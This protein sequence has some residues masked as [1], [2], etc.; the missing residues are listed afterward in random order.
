MRENNKK[1]GIFI[2]IIIV[3]LV[4]LFRQLG[5]SQQMQNAKI[6]QQ[7]KIYYGEENK[8]SIQKLANYDLVILEPMNWTKYGLLELKKKNTKI[9]GYLN[10]LEYDQ[11]KSDY[12]QDEFALYQDQEK[13]EIKAWDTIMLDIRQEEYQK[14]LFKLSEEYIPNNL[15]DGIF[16][17]TVGDID[18]YISDSNL[19]KQL[20]S[21]TASFIK[22][23]KTEKNYQSIIQNWGFDLY[24]DYTHEYI[25]I[26]LWEDFIKSK[27]EKDEWSLEWIDY[28]QKNKVDIYTITRDLQD[29]EYAATLGFKA[30]INKNDIYD[31]LD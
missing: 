29:S 15:Y 12:N 22:K 24:K 6:N 28:F 9:Y 1:Y 5:M 8:E 4:L 11:Y 17:D 18:D 21:G 2:I 23:L 27:I 16:L 26:V 14:K 7:F 20:A 31:N 25:D 10:V 3:L 13:V 19:K 30:S